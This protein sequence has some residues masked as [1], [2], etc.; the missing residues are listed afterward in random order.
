M[1][2]QPVADA[3]APCPKRNRVDLVQEPEL[4]DA[5]FAMV[6]GDRDELVEDPALVRPGVT[7]VA[8][9][10][11]DQQF[12][13]CHPVYAS[14]HVAGSASSA[15][16]Y[17]RQPPSLGDALR[18]AMQPGQHRAERVAPRRIIT[19]ADACA[20][21]RQTCALR[22]TRTID[23]LYVSASVIGNPAVDRQDPLD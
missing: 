2:D 3:L 4:P 20:L 5:V 23:R 11:R 13:L 22:P 16:L 6:S 9:S 7:L 14:T 8:L 12:L 18:E 17:L 21:A 19:S 10:Q 15:T 1:L